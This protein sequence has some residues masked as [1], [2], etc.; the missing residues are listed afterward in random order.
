MPRIIPVF[1]D[2]DTQLI[3]LPRDLGFPGAKELTIER[4]GE[5]MILRPVRPDWLSFAG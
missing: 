4:Q 5:R 1:R 3:C 2:H